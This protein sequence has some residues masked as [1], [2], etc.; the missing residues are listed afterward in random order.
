[1][2]PVGDDIRRDAHVLE[3]KVV[4]YL[5]AERVLERVAR[6]EPGRRNVTHD[7]HGLLDSDGLVSQQMVDRNG[8]ADQM[9][10]RQVACIDRGPVAFGTG[11]VRGLGVVAR[12]RDDDVS[13]TGVE[14]RDIEREGHA[15]VARAGRAGDTCDAPREGT[16]G[17]HRARR[18]HGGPRGSD[19]VHGDKLQVAWQ[20][21][22]QIQVG[23]R[24]AGGDVGNDGVLPDVVGSG[25]GFVFRTAVDLSQ[26]KDCR[27]RGACH[28]PR[29]TI[30]ARSADDGGICRGV[31]DSRI[32]EL[33]PGT[34]PH[35][36][37]SIQVRQAADNGVDRDCRGRLCPGERTE[38]QLKDDQP[39]TSGSVDPQRVACTIDCIGMENMP[40]RA[41]AG[42]IVVGK[43][44][45]RRCDGRSEVRRADEG[46]A[47]RSRRAMC[48]VRTVVR[49]H[50]VDEGAVAGIA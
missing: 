30:G 18:R 31:T 41:C 2:L 47:I 10:C 48:A 25:C 43:D 20:D 12:R 26:S 36:E 9:L 4:R 35:R 23:D 40:R 8:I 21:V 22:R 45:I 38:R 33:E 27:G 17:R 16:S 37:R 15:G 34:G 19:V 32:A 24:L 5:E 46:Q 29:R 11:V 49:E 14:E 39:V 44:Q 1:M 42:T 3:G 28:R 7:G 6:R 50:E 13:Q